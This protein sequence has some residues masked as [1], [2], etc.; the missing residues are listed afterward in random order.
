M[1]SMY[2]I[3]FQALLFAL[4]AIFRVG[5]T[6]Y[7]KKKDIQ[8]CFLLRSVYKI[9]MYSINDNQILKVY[10]SG[11]DSLESHKRRTKITSKLTH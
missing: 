9:L 10:N 1:S 6:N 4:R 5:A 2:E 11:R 3:L 8:I 7:K